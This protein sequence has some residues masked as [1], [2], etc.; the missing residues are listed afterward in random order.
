MPDGEAFWAYSGPSSKVLT[1]L[2]VVECS[3]ARQ[4]ERKEEM[5]GCPATTG[6]FSRFVWP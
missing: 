4:I 2:V 3:Q 6:D 5:R 1:S